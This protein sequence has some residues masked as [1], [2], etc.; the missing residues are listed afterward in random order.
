MGRG[1]CHGFSWQVPGPRAAAGSR[2]AGGSH[3][4]GGGPEGAQDQGSA[5]GR[6]AGPGEACGP[7]CWEPR[8]TPPSILPADSR[9]CVRSVPPAPRWSCPLI[10]GHL[11][12]LCPIWGP[13]GERPVLGV[14]RTL[15]RPCSLLGGLVAL[16]P[17]TDR[18]QWLCSEVLAV[19][20]GPHHSRVSSVTALVLGWPLF[21]RLPAQGSAP[22]CGGAQDQ[23]RTR[24]TITRG[25]RGQRAPSR[26][27]NAYT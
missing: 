18:P 17:P 3:Q 16:I 2:A 6:G 21:L 10:L 24:A 4:Q 13:I 15:P 8:P 12:A 25:V 19:S 23:A 26:A 27:P 22:R 5:A 14:R 7:G 9:G 11:L 20:L 1:W